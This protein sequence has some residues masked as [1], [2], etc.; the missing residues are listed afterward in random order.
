M[1]A[2]KIKGKIDKD[3]TLTIYVPDM[4]PGEV[5]II[6]L[7]EKTKPVP[8]LYRKEMEKS[9]IKLIPKHRVGR[10]SSDLSREN[11]YNDA[12]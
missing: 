12:R 10:I 9:L 1:L 4:P 8:K 6:I 2:K 7:T 5:E 11:I 3:N